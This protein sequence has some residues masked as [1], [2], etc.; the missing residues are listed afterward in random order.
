MAVP[1]VRAERQGGDRRLGRAASP[2]RRSRS[3]VRSPPRA[4]PTPPSTSAKPTSSAAACPPISP[5]R[6]AST[7]RRRKAGHLEAQTSLGL[8]L[9]QNNNR[10]A[11]L[12]WLKQASDARRTA[13]DAGLR[14]RPVQRR[15]RARR[16][17]PRLCAGQPL[18]RAGSC[19]GPHDAWRNGSDHPA[20]GA[21]ERRRTGAAA[22]D[23]LDTARRQARQAARPSRRRPAPRRSRRVQLTAAAAQPARSGSSSARFRDA[24]S[25]QRLFASLGGRAERRADDLWCRRER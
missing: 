19:P 16:P 7:S 8:L 1:A 12:R 14:H 20:R 23:R 11:A 5:R 6:S 9:F 22:G 13:R 18:R 15:R 24:A 25:A 2:S 21:A 3:G 4:R 17:H 10:A